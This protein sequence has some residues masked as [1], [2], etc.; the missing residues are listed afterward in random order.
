MRTD[1]RLPISILVAAA[2]LAMGAVQATA[3]EC[4]IVIYGD[5]AEKPATQGP[6][7]QK[8]DIGID[9]QVFF[10]INTPAAGYT[11]AE[12][13]RIVYIRLVEIMSNVH[14]R[15]ESFQ[16]SRVR[17]RPTICVG[18]YRLVTVY[19]RDAQAAGCSADELAGRW[20]ASLREKLP[21]VA[22]AAAVTNP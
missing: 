21:V 20:L 15:P 5:L 17:G 14:I 8:A 1:S 3:Q 19:P 12:R 11:V 18:N 16:L 9:G 10:T 7:M 22:P 2:L 13:E 4:Q 6:E